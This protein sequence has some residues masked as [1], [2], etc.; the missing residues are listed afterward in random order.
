MCYE[1]L[2]ALS[3]ESLVGQ[4]ALGPHFQPRASEATSGVVHA[5]RPKAE[6]FGIG[7]KPFHGVQA[8]LVSPSQHLQCPCLDVH[9]FLCVVHMHVV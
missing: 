5:L 2:S 4:S 9:M 3:I 7:W 6:A 1:E 8:H